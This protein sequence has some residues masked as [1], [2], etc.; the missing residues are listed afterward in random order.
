LIEKNLGNIL[1]TGGSGFIGTAL[2]ESLI[3]R[4]K[5][6]LVVD[7]LHEQ[8][9]GA[10]AKR[11]RGEES[12][13]M[14]LDV[15]EP[16]AW[17]KILSNFHPDVVVHLAAETGTGQ[18]LHFGSRHARVNVEGTTQMLDAFGRFD[19]IPERIILSGSRAVYGEGQWRL[20]GRD[21]YPGQR[22]HEQLEAGHWD[23]ESGEPLSSSV[24]D[25]RPSP[26]SIYGATKLAQEHILS[27]WSAAHKT[28]LTVLRFQN[29]Y[30]PGQSL[31]NSY[32]G[33]VSLFSQLAKRGES[34]PLYEDGQITRDF[35]YI[36][37]VVSSIRASLEYNQT[38]LVSWFDIGSGVATSIQ[39][40]A[41]VISDYHKAPSP[42]ITGQFRDGD[43]RHAQCS[44]EKSI[45]ELNW[46]P[47]VNLATGIAN[48]Q[49]WIA[50]QHQGIQ[51]NP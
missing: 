16:D 26:T 48:L 17:D 39:E 42:H 12:G 29:V 43:V 49:Q 2:K 15:A 44:I 13:L 30:G 3:R 21:F 41:E 9:H 34:I 18:S 45:N 4:A 14:V 40:L 47:R 35:V 33:I 32:T 31:I 23:F 8:V 10:N 22:S 25:T 37:D 5:S 20:N 36:S 7:N 6:W 28:K 19:I 38:D 27:A 50:E 46:R 11:D 51:P 1:V 24:E